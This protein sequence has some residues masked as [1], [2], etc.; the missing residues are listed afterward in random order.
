MMADSFISSD[1]FTRWAGEFSKRLDKQG[2]TLG[3]IEVHLATLNGRTSQNSAKIAD[4]ERSVKAIVEEDAKI[5]K[6][7]TDIHE[8]GCHQMKNHVRD[9]EILQDAGV[10][11]PTDR[12]RASD[13][14]KLP[15]LSTKQKTV[16]GAGVI[17]LLIP[18]VADLFAFLHK[19]ADWLTP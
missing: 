14:F 12:Y 16:A 9:V 15:T 8:H 17:A 10:L 13:T 1:E 19:V 4:V 6:V 3:R 18:A 5:D 2:E 7:V 11:V